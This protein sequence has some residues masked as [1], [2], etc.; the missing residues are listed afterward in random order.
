LTLIQSSFVIHIVWVHYQW[1]SIGIY[2][3]IIR[4]EDIVQAKEEK[5]EELNYTLGDIHHD[6]YKHEDERNCEKG[7]A[8]HTRLRIGTDSKRSTQDPHEMT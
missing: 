4:V 7:A 5:S 2:I 3:V 8:L 6:Q 1:Y